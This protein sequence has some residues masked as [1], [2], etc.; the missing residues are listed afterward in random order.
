MY[1]DDLVIVF[2][3]AAAN[4]TEL[5][6]SDVLDSLRK[7]IESKK[8]DLQDQ[9]LIEAILREDEKELVEYLLTGQTS[10]GRDYISETAKLLVNADVQDEVFLLMKALALDENVEMESRQFAIRQMKRTATSTER[11]RRAMQ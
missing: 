9:G 5:K 8:Y 1:I 4:Y 2:E 11:V 7:S 10:S 6:K 3:K